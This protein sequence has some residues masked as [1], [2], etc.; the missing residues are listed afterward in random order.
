MN[1]LQQGG[2]LMWPLLALSVA[3]L[4]VIL[5]R[6]V[7]FTTRRF[8]APAALDA[9]LETFRSR[10][11]EAAIK[12]A[13][14]N[15]P[16]FLDFFR[17]CFGTGDAARSEAAIQA[18]GEDVLFEFNARLDFLATTATAAPLMGLLGTVIGMI[19]AFSRLSASGDVDITML[20]GGIW[21]ALLT[22]AAG[23]CIAI[24]TLLAQRWFCRQCD[25]TA[26]AMQR[27]ARLAVQ[28]RERREDGR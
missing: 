24:P 6:F 27:A 22:T 26:F 14:E 23:L 2:L 16:A 1:I 11:G 5:E 9:L 7:V 4:A 18:A 19:N 20:A 28:W 12:D 8:P 21:Q 10:G 3:A 25:K 13:E 15:S 17:A